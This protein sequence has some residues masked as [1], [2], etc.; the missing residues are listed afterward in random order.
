MW[1]GVIFITVKFDLYYSIKETSM[2][3]ILNNSEPNIEF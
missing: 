2:T 3:C 1:Y